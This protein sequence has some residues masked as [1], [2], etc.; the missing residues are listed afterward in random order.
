MAREN[1]IQDENVKTYGVRSCGVCSVNFMR[2]SPMAKY[3]GNA[4][5][6]VGCQYKKHLEKTRRAFKKHYTTLHTEY[7]A[8]IK[9]K[10]LQKKTGT[11]VS[12]KIPKKYKYIKKPEER[13][14]NS[15]EARFAR[16]N[17]PNFPRGE[18]HDRWKG[19]DAT[20]GAIHEWVYRHLGQPNE[21]KRCGK[22]DLRKSQ[23]HWANI[24]HTY[25]RNKEDWIRLCVS[26]HKRYDLGQISL[27]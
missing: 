20:Y 21:C 8:R 11:F 5:L 16:K 6:K 25:K 1:V 18:K 2:R 24:G 10:F 22:N 19:D 17:S 13:Y 15:L 23:Y 27:I 7:R 3:C 14:L 9:E 26:C 12:K 4:V